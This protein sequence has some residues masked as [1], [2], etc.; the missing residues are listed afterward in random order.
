V[1]RKKN[2]LNSRPYHN[3]PEVKK[4][5]KQSYIDHNE[6]LKQKY[7]KDNQDINSEK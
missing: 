3:S 1:F 5:K 7:P 6:H 4:P 2:S